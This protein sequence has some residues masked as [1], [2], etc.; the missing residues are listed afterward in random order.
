M[1]VPPAK[2]FLALSEL[3]ARAVAGLPIAVLLL[4]LP[5]S[6]RDISLKLFSKVK[7]ARAMVLSWRCSEAVT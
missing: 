6:S 4:L 5:E 7:M 1:K 2:Y 3:P